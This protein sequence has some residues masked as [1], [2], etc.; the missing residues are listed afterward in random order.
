[1]GQSTTLDAPIVFHHMHAG[2]VKPFDAAL[3]NALECSEPAKGNVYVVIVYGMAQTES[4]E[5]VDLRE[6]RQLI[7]SGTL[8][9]R[10][11]YWQSVCLVEGDLSTHEWVCPAGDDPYWEKVAFTPLHGKGGQAT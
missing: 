8:A 6:G 1:M 11:P 3:D 7:G 5:V 2:C 10:P 4:G 9:E